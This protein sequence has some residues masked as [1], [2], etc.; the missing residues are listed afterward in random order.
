MAVAGIVEIEAGNHGTPIVQHGHQAALIEPRTRSGF[1]N[2]GNS[3]SVGRGLDHQS[4]VVERQCTGDV[5]QDL[6]SLLR[7]LPAVELAARQA[8]ADAAVLSQ[9]VGRYRPW[10]FREVGRRGHCDKAKLIA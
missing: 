9:I 5:D 10:P 6:L 2:V 8:I 7:K 1:G 3:Q 4:N